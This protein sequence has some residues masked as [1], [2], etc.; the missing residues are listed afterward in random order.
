MKVK[1]KEWE[2]DVMFSLY[3][4]MRLSIRLLDTKV[5][6]L[7]ATATVNLP[8][9]ELGEYQV[10]IKEYSENEGMTDALIKAGIILPEMQNS[11]NTGHVSV[12]AYEMTDTV[13]KIYEDLLI[14]SERRT[15][16]L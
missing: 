6:D 11:V 2:C 13:K 5:G 1:F 9:C 7:I 8:H 15:T 3:N 10:F 12:G 4:N 14:N 16:R